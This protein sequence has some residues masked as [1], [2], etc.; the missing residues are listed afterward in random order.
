MTAGLVTKIIDN[1]QISLKDLHVRIE[2]ED[3]AEPD[4]SFSIG[5]TLQGI[6][7]YTTDEN[8]QRVYIDRT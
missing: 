4:N 6:D 7:L 5:Y 3:C 2:H 8:W 1:L